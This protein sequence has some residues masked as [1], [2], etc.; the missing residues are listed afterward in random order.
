M[1]STASDSLGYAFYGS[2][3][4]GGVGIAKWW[5]IHM[6]FANV[7]YTVG[8]QCEILNQKYSISRTHVLLLKPISAQ[9]SNIVKQNFQN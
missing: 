1:A 9:G 5:R 7:S 2:M 4:S 8:Y 3:H 6:L